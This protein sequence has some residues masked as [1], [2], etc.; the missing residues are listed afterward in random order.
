MRIWQALSELDAY[1]ITEIPRRSEADQARP[2]DEPGPA[3]R[4][5]G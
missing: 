1:R 4:W 2:A 3:A 5:P